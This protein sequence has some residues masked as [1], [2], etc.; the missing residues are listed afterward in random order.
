MRAHWANVYATRP[1]DEVSWYE[2]VPAMSLVEVDAA[3]G[4]GATSL[5]DIGGGAS[6]LIDHLVNRDLTRLAV[7]DISRRALGIARNRLGDDARRVEWIEADVTK[8]GDLG[9][10]DVWH[11]RAVF[12][13]LTS[14]ADRARYVALCEQTVSQGGVA[15][16]ATFAP[17]G[18]DMC[19]GLPVNRYDSASLAAVCGKGFAIIRS[20]RI[21]HT[22]PSGALQ[23]F[24][25]TSFRRLAEQR[26]PLRV[27]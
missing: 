25:Y 16:V 21:V 24:V 22:T 9:Q 12:H 1:T 7:L 8:A 26:E 4:E 10:F 14:P 6:L 17:D 27:R 5:V 13:F 18:P 3:L 2:A 23:P 20:E 19:S 15:I 11:D